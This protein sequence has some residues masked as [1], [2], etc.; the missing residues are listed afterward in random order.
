MMRRGYLTRHG[1]GL[2]VGLVLCA[3]ALLPR[4]SA[5]VRTQV[6]RA[7]RAEVGPF[8]IEVERMVVERLGDRHF[9]FVQMHLFRP[10]GPVPLPRR[11]R[12]DGSPQLLGPWRTVDTTWLVNNEFAF[13]PSL[14]HGALGVVRHVDHAGE[15]RGVFTFVAEPGAVIAPLAAL[16]FE[17]PD[18]DAATIEGIRPAVR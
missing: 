10:D 17:L 8:V 4:G 7:P 16:K 3:A 11:V 1:L 6:E 14:R 18:G 12:I 5:P 13:R 15:A 2:T 9:A